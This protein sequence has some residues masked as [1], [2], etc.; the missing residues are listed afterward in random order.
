MLYLLVVADGAVVVGAH[1][2]AIG[3]LETAPEVADAYPERVTR[4]WRDSMR[5]RLAGLLFVVGES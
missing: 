4:E 2:A 1:R 5:L 3:Y